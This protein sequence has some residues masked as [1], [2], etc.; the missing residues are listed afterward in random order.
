[1]AQSD[2]I[3]VRNAGSTDIVRSNFPGFSGGPGNG[4]DWSFRGR[5]FRV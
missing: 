5:R 4:S 3:C 2:G 1:M